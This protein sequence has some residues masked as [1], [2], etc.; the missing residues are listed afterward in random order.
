MT[1]KFSSPEAKN[2]FVRASEGIGGNGFDQLFSIRDY[3]VSIFRHWRLFIIVVLVGSVWAIHSEVKAPKLYSVT[4]FV[5]PV[6]DAP[7]MN[8]GGVNGL[9]SMFLGGTMASG[10]PEWSRY[11]F[12]LNSMELAQKLE[13]EHHLIKG[14]VFASLWDEKTKTWKPNP[15][16]K[17]AMMRFING[18]FDLPTEPQPDVKMLQ[19]YIAGNVFLST[20][21]TTGLT[22]LSMQGPDPKKV[23]AFLLMVHNAAVN[24]VRNEIAERN[25]AKIEYLTRTL[26]IT[27]NADQRG[28]LIGMLAQAEQAKMLLNNHLPFAAQI[29][30]TPSVPTT[31]SSPP[32]INVML[33]YRIGMLVFLLLA[34][35]AFDQIAGTNFVDYTEAKIFG[36]PHS[37]MKRISR[38]RE[39]GWQGV[40]SRSE[41]L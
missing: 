3:I 31:P 14:S 20:D 25:T 13:D 39:Y 22:T 41:T 32:P 5:G 2:E 1:E 29:I 28:V 6:G 23:L 7:A 35:I 33:I 17:A 36:F 38:Y 27:S 24:L 40:F 11:V 9:V 8:S 26:A 37:V 10:P 16:F 15:G 30:D 34:L 12:V 18:L 21:K 4:L 19:S